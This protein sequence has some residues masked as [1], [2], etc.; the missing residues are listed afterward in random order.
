[1]ERYQDFIFMSAFCSLPLS[2]RSFLSFHF[3]QML[4]SSGLLLT[5]T[6]YH[7][8]SPLRNSAFLGQEEERKMQTMMMYQLGQDW[9]QALTNHCNL[10][11]LCASEDIICR[12]MWERCIKFF[13][14][15]F[16]NV[17]DSLV[18][19]V[20]P[21]SNASS[22]TSHCFG[23]FSEGQGD[24]PCGSA[25]WL[26]LVMQRHAIQGLA[27]DQIAMV[28]VYAIRM[29]VLATE[30][31]GL[32]TEHCRAS[33]EEHGKLSGLPSSRSNIIHHMPWCLLI[34]YC[35]FQD[36]EYDN[37][38]WNKWIDTSKISMLF[39]LTRILGQD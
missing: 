20:Q 35:Q 26:A 2:R 28:L 34:N 39:R 3:S 33:K 30:L 8:R 16:L 1:M 5:H 13:Y 24:A 11:L 10:R 25:C 17:S 6:L 38:E 36:K 32:L 29:A 37:I 15:H 14:V 4:W 19:L 21:G 7:K 18:G 23:E 31:Q 9:F 12:Y 27:T 22:K